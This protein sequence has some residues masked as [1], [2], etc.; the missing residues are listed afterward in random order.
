MIPCDVDDL[1]SDMISLY[2]ACK[3]KTGIKTKKY[4]IAP[5]VNKT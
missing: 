4:K 1:V 3:R 2:L 5:A